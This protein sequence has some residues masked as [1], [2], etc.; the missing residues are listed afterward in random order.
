MKIKII[1]AIL[2]FFASP[3][4]A[5]DPWTVVTCTNGE[6][7]VCR[8]PDSNSL[9]D[10]L[11]TIAGSADA[12]NN[13][14][15]QDG[16][17]L[18]SATGTWA[19]VLT[20]A[21][22]RGLH[23]KGGG[24][25][26]TQINCDSSKTC[27]TDSGTVANIWFDGI[28][29]KDTVG[30]G[31]IIQMGVTNFRVTNC[32]FT[33]DV[34]SST[35]KSIWATSSG[36]ISGS[37]FDGGLYKAIYVTNP[38][39]S[40]NSVIDFTSSDWMFFEGNTVN[41]TTCNDPELTEVDVGGKL[42]VRNNT[43]TETATASMGTV[44]DAHN[45]ISPIGTNGNVNARAFQFYNNR[46]IYQSATHG[47]K[48]AF[49]I[50]GGTGLIY[51]NDI[52]SSD[53][54][55]GV[56]FNLKNYRAEGGETW[57]TGGCATDSNDASAVMAGTRLAR[58]CSTAYHPN[59]AGVYPEGEGYPCVGQ[60]GWQGNYGGASEP[61][62]FWNN[63]KSTNGGSTWSA[64]GSAHV[65]IAADEAWSMV[66]NRDWIIGTK[67]YTSYTCPHPLAGLIGSCTATA[68]TGGYNVNLPTWSGGSCSGCKF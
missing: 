37:V 59:G 44:F 62:Y 61:I 50:R 7:G 5:A 63:R 31:A 60:P 17:Y 56:Y 9:S 23:I 10:V 19:D 49:Y 1:F 51:N 28:Y 36:V 39:T 11:A 30:G 18:K 34:A 38:Y 53:V 67:T 41:C 33:H 21:N 43:F 22:K 13:T 24:I 25:T 40:V 42:V 2:L 35:N 8:Q 15:I 32:R 64:L 54:E 12:G 45:V 29:F 20:I 4:F 66:E 6:A 68:G 65:A 46:V 47:T 27:I 58:C 14:T 48:R 26:A 3:A 16:I 52:S 57:T 55:I